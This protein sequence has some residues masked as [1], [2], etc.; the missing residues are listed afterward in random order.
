MT[1]ED[2]Q[3]GMTENNARIRGMKKIPAS[4]RQ[5]DLIVFDLDG[6]LTPSKANLEPDMSAVLARL[7]AVK[8]VAVIGGGSYGQFQRQFLEHFHPRKELLKNLFLFP[9]TSTSFYRYR[10]G[11]KRIYRKELLKREKRQIIR[12]FHEAF[13]E[14]HYV[15]PPKTYGKVIEDRGSQI[16]FSALGQ[17][18]VK[19]LGV[20]R[21]EA[22]KKKWNEESDIRPQLVRALR[23]RLPE[24]EHEGGYTSVDVTKP[25]I[26]KAYGVRQIKKT[27]KIPISKMLFIGDALYKGGNDEAAKKTGIDCV[28]VKGPGE[29]KKIIRSL[30]SH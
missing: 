30:T 25:G 11:W 29:T 10:I 14:I 16:T 20:K 1:Q 12:A 24:F 9:T 5:K 23:K 22:L 17:D 6:T 18:V 19:K 7:L 21:G 8:K 13:K 4:Y 3:L 2:H 26:D 27:L 15:P 28:A